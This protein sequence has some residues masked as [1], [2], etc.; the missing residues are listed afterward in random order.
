MKLAVTGAGIGEHPT[1]GDHNV[2]DSTRARSPEGYPGL[3]VEGP[4]VP[5]LIS[6][7]ETLSGHPK[8]AGLGYGVR[9][10][11]GAS[12]LIESN[13]TI[14]SLN[15]DKTMRHSTDPTQATTCA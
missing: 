13:D 15:K 2:V 9:P 3:D 8:I 14:R 10:N 5:C 7:H 4:N 11:C 12:S 1:A 6:N